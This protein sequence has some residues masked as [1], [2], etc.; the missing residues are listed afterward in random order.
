VLGTFNSEH[1]RRQRQVHV[2]QLRKLNTHNIW[3]NLR[4]SGNRNYLY[5]D[6]VMNCLAYL[7]SV[8]DLDKTPLMVFVWAME[9]LH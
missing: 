6:T 7:F 3:E 5:L 9:T 4:T 1:G 8:L 2:V